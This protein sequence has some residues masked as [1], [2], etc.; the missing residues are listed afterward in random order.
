MSAAPAGAVEEE[1]LPLSG[2]RVIDAAQVVAG[3]TLAMVLGDFGAEVIKVEQPGSGDPY[4][5][6]TRRKDG[7]PLGWKVLGRNKKSVTLDLGHPRAR[8]VLEPLI[9]R[10]DVLIQSFRPATVER[11]G[12]TYDELSR[13]N[14]GLVA[15]MVSGFGYSGPYRDRPGFGTLVEAMSGFADMTGTADRPPTLPAFALADS[16]AALYGAYGVMMALYVRDARGEGK[17]QWIDLSLLEPLFSILGPLTTLY[18]QLGVVPQRTGSRTVS[19][20]PRNVYETR[21]GRWLAIS[22]SVQ[23]M[24]ANTFAAIG[25]P[26]LIEDPR[27]ATNELRVQNVEALDEIVGA[28]ARER[29][30]DEALEILLRHSVPA[31]PVMDI[32]DLVRDPHMVAREAIQVVDDPELGPLRMHGVLPKMSR[33]SG[34]IRSAGPRLG[35]HNDDIYR[36]LLGLSE[37]DIAELQGAGV[38]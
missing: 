33:T 23:K 1:S 18:D 30:R 14:R 16:V 35:E 15:V 13:I 21:D 34:R 36:G 37:E 32:A 24:A 6:F 25:R 22:G 8:E 2:I 38:I 27:F 28:W 5:T 20:A 31:A 17:G 9:S 12:L 10:S 3:P 7:V 4:R 19:S 26:E 11:W 29:T